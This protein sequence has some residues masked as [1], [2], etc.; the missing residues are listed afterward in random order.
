MAPYSEDPEAGRPTFRGLR[1]LRDE[2]VAAG[3]LAPG[4]GL[5]MGMSGDFRVAVEEGATAIRVG[6]LLF[7]GLETEGA[8]P[9]A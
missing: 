8:A 3:V 9:H 1:G 5:S 7:A 2:L 6:S 4:A